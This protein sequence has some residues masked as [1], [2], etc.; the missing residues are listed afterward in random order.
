[1]KTGMK[2]RYTGKHTRHVNNGEEGVVGRGTHKSRRTRFVRFDTH[3]VYIPR[4]NLERVESQSFEKESKPKD[5][6][7]KELK[8][9][10]ALDEWKQKQR[11]L[12]MNEPTKYEKILQ[13][14]ERIKLNRVKR[15]EMRQQMKKKMEEEM[16]KIKYEKEINK[17]GPQYHKIDAKILSL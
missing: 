15:S 10:Q 13:N 14:R 1:M 17:I 16:E 12:K 2:V 5:L 4:H 3:S 7:P 6:S 11:E 9:R 8:R